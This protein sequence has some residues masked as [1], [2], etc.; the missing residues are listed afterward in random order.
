MSHRLSVFV[1]L[2]FAGFLP[3]WGVSAAVAQT[4]APA[5]EAGEALTLATSLDRLSAAATGLYDIGQ[6]THAR[7]IEKFV[8]EFTPRIDDGL[9]PTSSQTKEMRDLAEQLT[10]LSAMYAS[11]QPAKADVMDQAAATLNG[12]A[13]FY[14]AQGGVGSWGPVVPGG[15]P[16]MPGLT[17]TLSMQPEAAD[18][19]STRASARSARPQPTMPGYPGGVPG[20][21]PTRSRRS[22]SSRTPTVSRQTDREDVLSIQLEELD[23]QFA[24]ANE[25]R[26]Y[27]RDNLQ[28]LQN[29]PV[30]IRADDE[31]AWADVRDVVEAFSAAPLSG[32]LSVE[33]LQLREA[34][35][36]LAVGETPEGPAPEPLE[37]QASR[38]SRSSRSSRG[39]DC[40]QPTAM[41][42]GY[43][44]APPGMPYPMPPQPQGRP[45]RGRN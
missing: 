31:V 13:D 14:D 23:R 1:F 37:V 33:G 17:V 5:G 43:P 9:T 11:M 15:G 32:S 25:L 45:G 8:S 2:M 16:S 44:G 4:D 22:R 38:R 40:T 20:P 27:L 3:V 12:L 18:G 36:S 34:A 19:R 10:K 6:S 28:S 42:P 30:L 7:T 21:T 41:P 24:E 35:E 29:T 26:D 39:R